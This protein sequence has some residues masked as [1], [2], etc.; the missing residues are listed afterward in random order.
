LKHLFES[1]KV[2][3]LKR[4]G[5]DRKEEETSRHEEEEEEEEEEEAQKTIPIAKGLL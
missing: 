5:A 4:F 3:F 2:P 1:V